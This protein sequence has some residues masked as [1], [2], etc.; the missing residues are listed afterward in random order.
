M[1]SEDDYYFRVGYKKLKT[2]CKL[3]NGIRPDIKFANDDIES[4]L[5]LPVIGS[6]TTTLRENA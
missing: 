2:G 4:G 3:S 1:F 6:L 5:W